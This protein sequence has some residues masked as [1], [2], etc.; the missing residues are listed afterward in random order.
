MNRNSNTYTVIYA[1]VLT[2][3]VAVGLALAA[4]G[5]KPQQQANA[6]N[7][8]KQQVLSAIKSVLSEEPT[9]DNA[10]ALWEQLDMDANMF[11]VNPQGEKVEGVSAFSINTKA[12][13]SKGAV[14]ENATLPVYC[15]TVDGKTYYIMCMYGAGLWG[16]VWGYL[17]VESDG[18]TVAGATFD[19]ASET[20]GLGAK[21]K[22]DP[23]FAA[24][25][26][27]K[28]L[29]NNGQFSSIAIAKKG[30]EPKDGS[31]YTDA[32]SG[33]TLTCNGVTEMIR[34]SIGGYVAFL[35]SLNAA[36]QCQHACGTC[37][38]SEGCTAT[39]NV[40]SENNQ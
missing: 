28:K 36:G 21:I 19:H 37:E 6:A 34:S 39:T 31:S 14:I 27:G 12:Q 23:A 3:L 38:K 11:V 25:F 2:V 29:F 8:Q 9:F 7:E 24:S 5:L 30:K 1:T 13:F 16:P 33:A 17:S 10:A 15:A 20:A 35:Q 18:N 32:I 40:E 26:V 22:D 4:I